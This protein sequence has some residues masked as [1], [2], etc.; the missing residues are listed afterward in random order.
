MHASAHR[1]TTPQMSSAPQSIYHMLRCGG[2]IMVKQ[3]VTA[4]GANARASAERQ[5]TRATRMTNIETARAVLSAMIMEM[6]THDAASSTSVL[7]LWSQVVNAD[8]R[9]DLFCG[10]H[11]STSRRLSIFLAAGLVDAQQDINRHG[12]CGPPVAS[13]NAFA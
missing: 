7:M 13:M 6:S 12:T 8:A 9:F 5:A 3:F 2:S 10:G 1:R 4:C 11:R